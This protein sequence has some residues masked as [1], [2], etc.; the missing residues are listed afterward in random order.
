MTALTPLR[1]ALH[2]RRRD[3]VDRLAASV[4]ATGFPD[5]G[6]VRMLAETHAALEAIQGIVGQVGSRGPP[7]FGCRFRLSVSENLP[8][9]QPI[10]PHAWNVAEI[11][12]IRSIPRLLICRKRVVKVS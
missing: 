11:R 2:T 4:R 9:K 8:T 6:L 5:A 10:G 7:S 3:L 1:D 12:D